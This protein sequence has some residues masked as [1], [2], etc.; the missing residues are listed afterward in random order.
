M[1]VSELAGVMQVAGLHGGGSPQMETITMMN[2]YDVESLKS[3]AKYLFGIE[4]ELPKYDRPTVT[5]RKMLEKFRNLMK[6]K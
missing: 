4:G 5:P 6:G 3:I 2:R 1:I